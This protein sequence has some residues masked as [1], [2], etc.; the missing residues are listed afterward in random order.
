MLYRGSWWCADYA[1]RL[2]LWL[3]DTRLLLPANDARTEPLNI[4]LFCCPGLKATN[5]W[6]YGLVTDPAPPEPNPTHS[7]LSMV[8]II[9]I[10]SSW[11]FRPSTSWVGC[12]H[13]GC[14]LWVWRE[15][16]WN[17]LKRI[18]SIKILFVANCQEFP[19]SILGSALTMT[20]LAQP[21][22]H[23]TELT[24]PFIFET[25]FE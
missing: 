25:C 12:Q 9:L 22:Q 17:V 24:V 20:R 14:W 8:E 6:Y 23:Y 15:V 13:H 3:S 1:D 11:F 19:R 18:F 4:P 10:Q 16:S 21:R 5:C 7:S 2:L